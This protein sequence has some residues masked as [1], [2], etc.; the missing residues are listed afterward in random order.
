[1]T[2]ILYRS[3]HLI[4]VGT[5]P[6][7]D[8]FVWTFDRVESSKRTS[9][10]TGNTIVVNHHETIE[11]NAPSSATIVDRRVQEKDGVRTVRRLSY[12]GDPWGVEAATV[13]RLAYGGKQGFSIATKEG[14][15]GEV[16]ATE[17][18]RRA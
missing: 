15:C 13:A 11:V 12:H 17:S 6:V 1:M 18:S 10:L 5:H 7:V 4:Y 3:R 2:I 14:N 8:E 16:Q 9:E